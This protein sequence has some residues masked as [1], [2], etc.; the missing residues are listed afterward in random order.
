[1]TQI[2]WHEFFQLCKYLNLSI[3]SSLYHFHLADQQDVDS[4][5]LL[6]GLIARRFGDVIQE[7]GVNI[8]FSKVLQRIG[9]KPACLLG[10]LSTLLDLND[11]PTL[12]FYYELYQQNVN[13]VSENPIVVYVNAALSVDEYLKLERHSDEILAEHAACSV[14]QV[15]AVLRFLKRLNMVFFDGQKYQANPF[16][17]SFSGLANPKLR[18]L[19]KH[20]ACLVAE[21]Y[22]ITPLVPDPHRHYNNSR[23]SVFVKAM[24]AEAAE[25]VSQ[26]VVKFHSDID[27]IVKEDQKPKLN[28]Q[29]ILV[30]S[31]A[32]NINAPSRCSSK[33]TSIEP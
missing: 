1:M 28:V 7:W 2:K 14:E 30:Q 3:K 15:R 9:R 29:V 17:F 19:T 32:S 18:G 20:T 6:L 24:S 5:D 4:A 10:W 27:K 23:S 31:F 16:D 8:A 22:P 13:A 26:L 21:R 33:N 12:K 25:K 11:I